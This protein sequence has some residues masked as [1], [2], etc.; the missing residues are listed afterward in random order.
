[1]M[2][3]NKVNCLSII[4]SKLIYKY[5][6]FLLCMFLL[7]GCTHNLDCTE[8][9]Q[10]DVRYF[11]QSHREFHPVP[12]ARISKDSFDLLENKILEEC[13]GMR[14]VRDL[15]MALMKCN[16]Y[17]DGHSICCI[18]PDFSMPTFDFPIE[19][20]NDSIY[21]KPSGEL[22]ISLDTFTSDRYLEEVKKF[23]AY[24]YS[25]GMKN[26]QYANHYYF[27]LLNNFQPPRYIDLYNLETQTIRRQPFVRSDS[28]YNKGRQP[29][30]YDFKYFPEDSIAIFQYNTSGMD[31]F[32]QFQDTIHSF[33]DTIRK[34]STKYLFID[35]RKNG[36]G[37]D[38]VHQPIYEHLQFKANGMEYQAEW[39]S[40]GRRW[41]LKELLNTSYAEGQKGQVWKN[42]IQTY[43]EADK[44]VKKDSISW[45]RQD[46]YDKDVFVLQGMNTFSA[47]YSFCW[48]MRSAVPAC[49][50]VGTT[51]G[52]CN[53]MFGNAV[54][55]KLPN[56][57][58]PFAVA[59]NS[60]LY[61][62]NLLQENGFL[63]PDIPY[64]FQ[65][66]DSVLLDE[67]KQIIKLKHIDY[68]QDKYLK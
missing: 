41:S 3:L 11:F 33:F 2:N 14:D 35:V 60:V 6:L 5:Q 61:K 43:W 28:V 45:G 67:L 17:F 38:L 15:N 59:G 27:C 26:I 32:K 62:H 12:Y 29:K 46:G 37:S 66:E 34:L 40:L 58:I 13:K 10:E 20:K 18:F 19:V 39:T 42:I 30:I 63:K 53:P 21:W 65:R 24:D 68:I 47:A 49:L 50:L 36:G 8:Q 48:K 31:D 25:P 57:K 64:S 52:Q 1:M 22:V 4:Q 51:V 9:Y 23:V 44:M 55:Q 16:Q 54:L 56:T 7:C